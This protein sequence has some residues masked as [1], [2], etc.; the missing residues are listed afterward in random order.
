MYFIKFPIFEEKTE[1]GVGLLKNNL[2]ICL[3]VLMVC[4]GASE[5]AMGQWAST[6]A[7]NALGIDKLTGD[8]LGPCLF[9][10]FMG[11]GRTVFGIKGD[12]LNYKKHM[13][14][15]WSLAYNI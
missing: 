9:A 15:C 1:N 13:I 6:F 12:N 4:A 8:L 3:A 5:L 11:I 10:F 7:Q 14:I 2:F